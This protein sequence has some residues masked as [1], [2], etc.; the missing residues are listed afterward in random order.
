MNCNDLK[1]TKSE[2]RTQI[3]PMIKQLAASEH[4]NISKDI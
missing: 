1:V 2:N 3:D 4:F